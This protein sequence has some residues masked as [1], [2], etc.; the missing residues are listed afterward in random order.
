MYSRVNALLMLDHV[1][2]IAFEESRCWCS[3]CVQPANTDTITP[4]I[5]DSCKNATSSPLMTTLNTE[6]CHV[7][8]R[9]CILPHTVP[10]TR[11]SR[12]ADFH[13]S[14]HRTQKSSRNKRC[15]FRK[16]RVADKP[17]EHFPW[18]RKALQSRIPAVTRFT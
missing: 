10:S 18:F 12:G 11:D 3:R 15:G 13:T 14:S 8:F 1:C 2:V 9:N 5:K 16:P 17:S 7:T 6:R 4:N